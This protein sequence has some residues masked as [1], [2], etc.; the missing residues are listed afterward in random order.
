MYRQWPNAN[1]FP[2]P[3]SDRLFVIQLCLPCFVQYDSPHAWECECVALDW[4]GVIDGDTYDR[5]HRS[6][7]PRSSGHY[8][9]ISLADVAARRAQQFSRPVQLS[10]SYCILGECSCVATEVTME[11]KTNKECKHHY[12]IQNPDKYITSVHSKSH[13]KLINKISSKKYD[14]SRNKIAKK[15]DYIYFNKGSS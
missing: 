9:T 15:L 5:C 2:N 3:F 10:I 1:A 13:I 11:L 8:S 4:V 7:R 14:T 12:N 6:K